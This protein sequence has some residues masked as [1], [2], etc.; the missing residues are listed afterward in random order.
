[1]KTI[2]IQLAALLLWAS[3]GNEQ[4]QAQH[5]YD[6]NNGITNIIQ[7][8]ELQLASFEWADVNLTRKTVRRTIRLNGN[9]DVPPQNLVSVSH[10]MGGYV[11]AI[12]L[13]PGAPFRKGQVL[14]VLEDN[15]YIQ[16]QQ[17]YLI[18][19]TELERVEQNYER[20]K[21]LN[22]SKASSDK[23]LQAAAAEYQTLHITQNA[24]REKLRL[25][26][27]DPN[28][29]TTANITRQI[30]IYAPFNGVMGG[31]LVNQGKYISPTDV[32]F[33][34]INPEEL[35]LDLKVFEKDWPHIS[36]GQK[37]AAYTNERP[38]EVM[39][40]EVIARGSHIN[41]SGTATIHARLYHPVKTGVAPGMYVNAVVEI[42]NY[43]AYVL[44]EEAVVN[45]EGN[46]YVVEILDNNIFRLV[47]VQAGATDNGLVE[48]VDGEQLAGKSFVGEGAYTILMGMKN[49][50]EE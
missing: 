28:Q 29:L 41:E 3:C 39:E 17:D 49:K 20:Q 31:V 36:V 45:Y 26:G 32:L 14:A 4:Q 11:Q 13:L 2:A 16:L 25:I 27:V 30:R 5:N 43:E 38:N 33:E 9:V 37:L 44:P 6:T 21:V 12:H 22:E 1:M 40:G 50:T 35:L 18:T 8:S 10:A 47:N 34:L 42:N 19:T 24:L 15:Q 48:I 46:Q 23:S 7:L